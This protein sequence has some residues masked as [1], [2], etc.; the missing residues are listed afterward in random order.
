MYILALDML[1]VIS[2]NFMTSQPTVQNDNFGMLIR[3]NF[4]NMLEI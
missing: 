2:S 3:G 1:P 4:F